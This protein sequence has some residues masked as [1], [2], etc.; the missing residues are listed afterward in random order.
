MKSAGIR[1]SIDAGEDKL[2]YRMRNSQVNKVPYTIVVGDKE[3]EE[4]TVT[5]RHFGCK[6]QHTLKL[7]EFIYQLRNEI[8]DK[9]LPKYEE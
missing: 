7:E 6:S 5:Y 8:E 2:G 3:K 4:G 9:S 1:A